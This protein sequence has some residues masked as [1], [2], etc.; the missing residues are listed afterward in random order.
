MIEAYLDEGLS[1]AEIARRLNRHRSTIS[2]EIK[3]GGEERKANSLDCLR[4]QK[5]SASN[6]A[7]MRKRNCGTTSKANS[8]IV[9]TILKYLK[10]KYSPVQIAHAISSVKVCTSTIYNWVSVKLS[11]LISKV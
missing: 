6:L 10:M 4:Y 11:P 9:K 1:Q 2:L 5:T 3:R 7:A 8:H